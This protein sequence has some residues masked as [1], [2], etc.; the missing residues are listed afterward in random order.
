V[1]IT[2]SD[3]NVSEGFRACNLSVASLARYLVGISILLSGC[4]SIPDYPSNA[5]RLAAAG[6][7]IGAQVVEKNKALLKGAW[8]AVVDMNKAAASTELHPLNTLI[9]DA[10][11]EGLAGKVVVL[12]RESGM[13]SQIAKESAKALSGTIHLQSRVQAGTTAQESSGV[14]MVS[15]YGDV[16]LP[17]ATLILAYR[18]LDAGVDYTASDGNYLERRAVVYL[19]YEFIDAATGYIA[20]ADRQAGILI[21][22]IHATRKEN[23]EVSSL[24][25][26]VYPMPTTTG[27]G[28]GI[29]LVKEKWVVGSQDAFGMVGFGGLTDVEAGGVLIGLGYRYAMYSPFSVSARLERFGYET[30]SI[31]ST[32][33]VVSANLEIKLSKY[34]GFDLYAL[35]GGGF[36]SDELSV[37]GGTSVSFLGGLGGI[38]R[39]NPWFFFVEGKAHFPQNH[40]VFTTV[41][42]VNVGFG[43]RFGGR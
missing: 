39:W 7:A 18:V 29:A 27:A 8:V 4:A 21:D 31:T 3:K 28:A 25:P 37:P 42:A 6:K 23:V 15:L 36:Y 13:L 10:L 40:M 30:A 5:D 20:V 14:D 33:S 16:S 34:A 24:V 35:L 26:Y 12:E 11:V 9:R 19:Y 22:K 41:G 38:Y 2:I 17:T 1:G 32:Y 43:Y